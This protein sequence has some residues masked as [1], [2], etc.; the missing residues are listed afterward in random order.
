MTSK[1]IICSFMVQSGL[2]VNDFKPVIARSHDGKNW[3]K[4]VFPWKH[5]SDSY[6]I[7]GSISSSPE[8]NLFFFGT[9][10]KIDVLGES[11]WS[12]ETQGLKENELIYTLSTDRGNTWSEF[13]VIPKPVPGAA[14]APG[15]MCITSG[16]SWHVCYSPYNTFNKNIFVER[17]QVIL[18]TSRDK[19]ENWNYTRMLSFPEKYA[20]AAEAWIIELSD[21][22]LFGTCW[23]I[24]QK[25]NTDFSNPYA[26][27]NDDGRTWTQTRPT[28]IM[29]QTPSV[30]PLPGNRILFVYNQRRLTPYGIRLAV[31]TPAENDFRIDA[32]EMVYCA[33]RPSSK[34]FA[35]SHSDWTNFSFGEPHVAVLQDK[36]ILVVFWCI[37]ERERGIRYIRL[38]AKDIL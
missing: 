1:E 16:G 11:F 14:E 7:F 33:R 37:E 2:G 21:G 26:I 18:L 19:G 10:T 20:T 15:A 36:T 3:E 29:G 27:S 17:N 12:E 34:D 6:S 31:A 8:G 24:N 30:A 4:L 13:F 32:D 25:D 38:D 35:T 23:K 22:K 28:T 9:R 5:L